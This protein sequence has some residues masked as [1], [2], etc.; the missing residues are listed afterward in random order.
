MPLRAKLS[1]PK[2]MTMGEQEAPINGTGRFAVRATSDS[3]FAWLRTRMAVE[4][5]LMAWLRTATALIGFGFTID[6][7]FE[8]LP[9][10]E[11]VAPIMRSPMPRYLG[12]A[13]IGAGV[14]ALVI[15]LWEYR[16]I[17]NYLSGP[18]FEPVAGVREGGLRTPLFVL[19]IVLVFIGLF[20]FGAVLARAV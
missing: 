2:A 4:R 17:L 13:L 16:W 19:A 1:E 7:F 12:L 3:H 20:A 18:Q 5:T 15:S 14:L 9:T 11:S 10:L 6:Q 8:G